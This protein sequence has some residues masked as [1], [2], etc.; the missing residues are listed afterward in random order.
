MKVSTFISLKD[1]NQPF[2]TAINKNI[3]LYLL[4]ILKSG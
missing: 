1:I 3:D 4:Y 2:A